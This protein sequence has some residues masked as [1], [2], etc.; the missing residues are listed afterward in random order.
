M[1]CFKTHQV[2]QRSYQLALAVA[3]GK[4]VD[5][6][7]VDN[8]R[9]ALECIQYLKDQKLQPMTFIPLATCKVY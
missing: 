7:I 3:M 2:T 5:S 6:V 8:E 4:D 9:D 1:E